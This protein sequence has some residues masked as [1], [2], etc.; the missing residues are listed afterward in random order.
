[1]LDIEAVGS[2]LP[3]AEQD[4]TMADLVFFLNT[5]GSTQAVRLKLQEQE[6]DIRRLEKQVRR[7]LIGQG[8][9]DVAQEERTG[10]REQKSSTSSGNRE[11]DV[12]TIMTNLHFFL[13]TF[14][15]TRAVRQKLESQSQKITGLKRTAQW[16]Q[17]RQGKAVQVT[18]SDTV[19]SLKLTNA[20]L[21]RSEE[22]IT[23]I[24]TK[25]AAHSSMSSEAIARNSGIKAM[26]KTQPRCSQPGC[27]KTVQVNGLC[28]HHGGYY[29]CT[30]KDCNRRAVTKYLCHMH[31]GGKICRQSDCIKQ[32]VSSD[33]EFC[34]THAREQA[35]R[36]EGCKNFQVKRGYCTKHNLEKAV[37]THTKKDILPC[38]QAPAP[39][40]HPSTPKLHHK[41][42]RAP[43]C[44][45]WVMRNGDP[46]AYCIVHRDGCTTESGSS[47]MPVRLEAPID[48]VITQP[49]EVTK[50]EDVLP[51]SKPVNRVCNQPGCT[52]MNLQ[53][54]KKGFCFRHGGGKT[55][56]VEGCT[57]KQKRNKRCAAHG[58]YYGCKAEGCKKRVYVRGYCKSHLQERSTD[59]AG[60]LSSGRPQHVL[61]LHM[62]K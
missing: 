29:T 20:G 49:T 52:N 46:N 4:E 41:I 40:A 14:G 27:K 60:N 51:P 18:T 7:F 58:G 48:S 9:A 50:E 62:P 35:C 5:F 11:E 53:G 56:V 28:Y 34:S 8:M 37:N 43:G 47:G 45:K 10:N 32:I 22:K 15:S 31:G 42:C 44:M 30:F 24:Q 54:A 59:N 55:C 19:S 17:E 23:R 38:D 26:D 33:M 39:E 57:K 21:P 16:F 36:V 61:D 3:Q 6:K 1:M 12:G 13:Q 25:P 2:D